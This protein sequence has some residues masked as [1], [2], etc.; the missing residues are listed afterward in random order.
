MALIVSFNSKRSDITEDE[1]KEYVASRAP[2]H[3][4]LR[5]GV[6]FTQCLPMTSSGKIKRKEIR[7]KVLNGEI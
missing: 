4:K 7:D 5:G 6:K 2:D 1:I 3:M